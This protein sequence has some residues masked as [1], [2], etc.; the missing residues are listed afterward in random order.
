[1]AGLA[2]VGLPRT[3]TESLICLGIPMTAEELKQNG[4]KLFKDR[5]YAAAVSALAAAVEHFPKD[6]TLW[7][8]LVLSASWS[9]QHEM[10]V[11][12]CKQS[13]RLHPRSDWLWRQ[14]GSDLIALDKLEEA[15]KALDNAKGLNFDAPWLWRYFAKLYQK[16]KVYAKEIE[17]LENLHDLGE[18]DENDLNG[19]GIAYHNHGNFAKAVEFYRLSAAKSP[20][21]HQFFNMG[22]VFSHPEVS[23]DADAADAYLRTLAVNPDHENAKQNLETV[24]R[25]LLPLAQRARSEAS[26][27]IRPAEFFQFYL[28]PFEVFRIKEKS[29][30]DATTIQRAK[31]ELV[32]EIALCD[33]KIVWL[34]NQEIDRARA[35]AL[36]NELFDEKKRRFHWVVFESQQLLR[37]LTRGEIEHFLY[38][39]SFPQDLLARLDKEPEFRSF[40]SKPFAQQYNLILTRAIESRATAVIEALFDGR[41]WVEQE[42]EDICFEGASK[43]INEFVAQMGTLA[44]QGKKRKVDLNQIQILLSERGAVELFN[45]L[46]TA[47]RPAQSQ[48]VG[49]LR[50][51]AIDCHNEHSD[52]ELSA[53]ILGL[54]K[55]FRF[56]SADLNKQ[57]EDDSKALEKI[58]TENRKHSFSAWVQQNQPVYV[59]H[60]GIKYAGDSIPAA[61]VEAIRWGICV[62]TINGIQT[63]YS[64]TLNVSSSNDFV[65]VRW[66]KRGVVGDVKNLFRKKDAVV[67]ISQLPSAD[68][69]IWFQK[70][71]DA[72]VHNLIPPLVTKL[73]GRLQNDVTVHVGPCTLVQSGIAFRT[74][75]IFHK[76][77][78]VPWRD[79]ETQMHNGQVCVFNRRTPNVQVSMAARDTDNAVVLPILC[80][81]MRER[82][83]SEQDDDGGRVTERRSHKVPAKKFGQGW[84]VFVGIVVMFGVMRACDSS[85]T[86]SSSN[87]SAPPQTAS[88][89]T[90]TTPSFPA[91]QSSESKTTYHIPS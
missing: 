40:L 14:L 71:V 68:Q 87:S 46:P 30:L 43:R 26:G 58:L 80:A 69:E 5:Q 15:E 21:A 37:F 44:E 6:E 3:L 83:A 8:E 17:A 50:S 27:L 47:F 55:Q 13:I 88:Q 4:Q 82:T 64:F 90:Y 74:G 11:G 70:M 73:V 53:Q 24:K 12:Y 22:L 75:L 20:G 9:K 29:T 61:D 86:S 85:N 56:K 65:L 59:T 39:D 35:L 32:H 2:N 42:D 19:L 23:Q 76:D 10:A 52:S 79:A 49:H 28:N 45:L 84:L 7:Q 33:G 38:T 34:D 54:C 60:T 62:R 31:K 48:L 91:P 78:L 81:A 25:K 77:H 57:L 66:D 41:R 18:A 72:V 67:P 63:E 36:E 16:Q 1:V 51:L 89:P